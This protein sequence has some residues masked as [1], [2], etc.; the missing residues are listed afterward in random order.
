MIKHFHSNGIMYNESSEKYRDRIIIR[1][2]GAF[3][4]IDPTEKTVYGKYKLCSVYK[5]K[6]YKSTLS[7][8]LLGFVQSVNT[9]INKVC[10]LG[11]NNGVFHGKIK[12]IPLKAFSIFGI[13]VL[14]TEKFELKRNGNKKPGAKW[15]KPPTLKSDFHNLK[16]ALN[17][18]TEIL[19]KDLIDQAFS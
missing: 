3:Y 19:D 10:V 5:I 18:E 16:K 11:E 12:D 6:D 7:K 9:H 2:G 14:F 15:P 1:I 13:M 8:M 4:Q 17:V